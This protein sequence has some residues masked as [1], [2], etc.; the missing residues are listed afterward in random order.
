MSDFPKPTS[1]PSRW[2]AVVAPVK[3]P[4]KA[5]SSSS[6]RFDTN[7]S[8]V[9]GPGSYSER[10]PLVCQSPS[11][12]KKGYGNS[13]V[14]KSEK[15]IPLPSSS[16]PGPGH[17]NLKGVLSNQFYLEKLMN[18]VDYRYGLCRQKQTYFSICTIWKR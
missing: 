14:S 3:P 16:A 15:G 18:F 4:V 9:P 7:I 5:F 12:S 17:Y 1:I 11:I 2:E 8:D 10:S 6:L 13:F